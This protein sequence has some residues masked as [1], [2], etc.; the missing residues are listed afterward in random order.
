MK[1][2]YKKN[3]TN[4]PIERSDVLRVSHWTK[5]GNYINEEA[6]WIGQRIVSSI[7]KISSFEISLLLNELLMNKN[8]IMQDE[9]IDKRDRGEVVKIGSNYILT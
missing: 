2:S 6:R 1:R 9:L 4:E 3:G 7:L 8:S 5:K